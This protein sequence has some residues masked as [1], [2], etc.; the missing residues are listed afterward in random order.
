MPGARD[1]SAETAMR[2]EHVHTNGIR[3]H[4]AQAGPVDG[5]LVIL[6]HG[7]PE[8]WYGWRKQMPALAAAGYCVWAPDQRGYNLSDKPPKVRDYRLGELAADVVGLID[9]A[10]RERAMVVG[11]DWGGAVAWW[12]AT[13]HVERLDKLAIIN[14]PHPLVMRRLLSTSPRQLLKSWY[15]FALQ[16]PWLPEF[17][18]RRNEWR[19]LIQTMQSSSRPG[20]FSD[21]DFAEYRKAWSQPGA[22]TAMVNWYRAM[23]RHGAG[24]TRQQRITTPT[25][26]LWGVHDKFISRAGAEKSIELCERGE[27]VLFDQAGHWLPHEEPLALTANLLDFLGRP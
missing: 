3:L 15:M 9:A 8:F 7:F 23:F 21:G 2:F 11:H 13:N 27:L 26:V 14:V 10:G 1:M 20:T 25:L 24:A 17:V 4:V 5:P 22:Y 12:M 18:A 16:L 19:A 6:L